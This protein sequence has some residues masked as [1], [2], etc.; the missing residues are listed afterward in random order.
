MPDREV[1]QGPLELLILRTLLFGSCHGH[2][3][4]EHIQS[5]SEDVLQVEH[6][7]LYPV[8]H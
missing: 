7:S 4:A 3:I 2:R 1:V 5:T 8:A 6:G